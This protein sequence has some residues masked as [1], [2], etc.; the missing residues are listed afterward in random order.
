[1]LNLT[2]TDTC[3]QTAAVFRVLAQEAHRDEID[4]TR[5]QALQT[6]I[7][8]GPS[9]VSIPFA[10]RL[11]ELVPPVAVRLR[12]DF[13]TVLM[14]I[15]AHAMLHQAITAKRRGRPNHC[16]DPRLCGRA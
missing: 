15:R 16:A 6:W 12:R 5:W 3:E 13:K 4:L 11:A 8:T 9:R 14:L 7:A 10:H 1:M 2:I